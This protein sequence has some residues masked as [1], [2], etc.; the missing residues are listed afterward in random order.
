MALEGF[1]PPTPGLRVRCSNQA[2]LQSPND[3]HETTPQDKTSELREFLNNAK[4]G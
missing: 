2:E 4:T 3:V 1:E